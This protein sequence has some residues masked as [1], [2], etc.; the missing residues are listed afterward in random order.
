MLWLVVPAGALA[1]TL[2]C[3]RHKDLLTLVLGILGL[4]VFVLAAT[5]LHGL[6]GEAGE[7]V[8]TVL[9]AIA[10]TAA[11]VRNFKLCRAQA[12]EHECDVA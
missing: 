5:T 6:L 7:R 12:C 8:V 2:G 4:V 11:H 1:F 10:L 3:W 9:S